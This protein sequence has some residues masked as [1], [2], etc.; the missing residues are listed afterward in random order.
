MKVTKKLLKN[1]RSMEMDDIRVFLADNRKAKDIATEKVAAAVRCTTQTVRNTEDG[2]CYSPFVLLYEIALMEDP[3]I[4][5]AL[6]NRYK[7]LF[8]K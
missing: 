6:I 2:K 7:Q 5:I 3:E 8:D 4:I 1:I